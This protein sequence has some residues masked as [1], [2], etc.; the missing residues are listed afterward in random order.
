MNNFVPTIG[1]EVHVVIDSKTKM[2]S[3]SRSS[4]TGEFN[5]QI[6]EID[7][8]LPGVLPSPNKTVVEKAIALAKSFHME[9]DQNIR[10]DRKNYFYQDLPKGFQITQQFFPIGKEGYLEIQLDDNTTKRIEIERIHIEEDTAKQFKKDDGIYLDFNRAGMP[11]IEIVTKPCIS[12]ALE[13][14]LFLKEL[15]K[16]LQFNQISDAKMEEGSMRADINI[17]VAPIGSDI[18]GVRTEVK[19]VNSISNVGKAIEFEVQRKI[20]LILTNQEQIIDTRR[21][22]DTKMT[23]VFMREKTTNVDYR[24]MTEPNILAIK[25]DDNFVQQSI[26]KYYVDYQQLENELGKYIEDSSVLK[27]IFSEYAFY[28]KFMELVELI[29]PYHSEQFNIYAEAYKWLFIEYNGIIAKENISIIDVD[30]HD[31][32]ALAT[33]IGMIANESINGKQAKS[34]L[35]EIFVNKDETVQEMVD[36]LGY[37]QINDKDEIMSY[38]LKYQDNE[39]LNELNERPEK[40]EKFFIG[41]I[42]KDTNGQA[43]PNVTKLAYEEFISQYKNK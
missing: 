3:P 25:V 10:F 8:G 5:T 12:S 24:Y 9:I 21:F 17:S 2:F 26:D 19:N 15:R 36:R 6:N 35:K 14:E 34:L 40:V 1:I 16:T 32:N 43:N 38:I 27:H 39:I 13:A 23:T 41:K 22:D 29:K 30:D 42:M 20:E 33:M 11:L 28:K 31:M 18:Y 4:H 7:L 37:K